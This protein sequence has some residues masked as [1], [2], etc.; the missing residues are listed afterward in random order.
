MATKKK[1]APES[2]GTSVTFLLDR[3]GSMN[4]I[5]A[6]TIE[7][8]NAYLKGLKEEPLGMSFSLVQFDSGGLEKVCV[9]VPV[10]TAP[11]LTD[12]TYQPRGGTPLIDAAYKTIRAVEKSLPDS[13]PKVVICIQ[14]DGEE[15]ESREYS[16]E[17]LRAL[18]AEKTKLGW[19]F[20]FMGAGIDAYNQGAK[21]GISRGQTMSYDSNDM[22]ATSAA[23]T[24]SAANTRSFLSG[25]SRDTSYSTSQKMAAG[26]KFDAGAH[27][28]PA[29]PVSPRPTR[30][31]PAAADFSLED[32]TFSL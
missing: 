25:Q 7:A 22:V 18:I 29:A 15:N 11:E 12:A 31:Q 23:F 21:M 28:S 10:A 6:S 32:E 13:N 4:A 3:S 17:T 8:F 1:A 9:R 24:A 16:W 19:Q 26:D 5:K 30:R 27:I 2:T 20:N 14:T